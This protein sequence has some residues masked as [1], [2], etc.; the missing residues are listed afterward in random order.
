MTLLPQAREILRRFRADPDTQRPTHGRDARAPTAIPWKGWVEIAGRTASAV[1]AHRASTAAAAISFYAMLAFIPALTCAA[2]AYGLLN[3]T[4]AVLPQALA[5]D[6]LVPPDALALIEAEV[7]RVSKIPSS[8]L[9]WIAAVAFVATVGSVNA[10][11]EALVAALNVA[12]G[13][14][15]CRPF[16]RRTLTV[17]CFSATLLLAAPAVFAALLIGRGLAR[18]LDMAPLV[19]WVCRFAFLAAVATAGLAALYR[20]GPCR[21]VAKWRWVTPGGLVAAVTWLVS[22]AAVSLYLAWFGRYQQNYGILGA[23]LAV[24]GWLWMASGVIIV[25]AELNAQVERQT[26]RDTTA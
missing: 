5:L 10:A 4:E 13:E 14:E 25:G 21:E 12:N 18:D 8:N 15:E 19:V 20:Y 6:G 26:D 17:A 3:H 9:G 11:I 2:A 22:S 23:V 24:L 1:L 7:R 16:L